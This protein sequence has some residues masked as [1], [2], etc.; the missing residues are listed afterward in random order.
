NQGAPINTPGWEAQ[1]AICADGR[2]LYFVSNRAGGFGGNDLWKSEL[3]EDG[4]WQDPVNLGPQINTSFSE[5]SP[6]IHADN[7]TLYFASSGWTGL[8]GQDT[9]MSPQDSLV[10]WER[11]RNL[12][13]PINNHSD[14]NGLQVT[15]NVVQGF[16]SS[17]DSTGQFH[18]YAFGLP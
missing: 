8:C 13:R 14:Q 12:G 15:M 11:P 6:Y 4:V 10:Q 9:V 1:P 2:T 3:G 7:R 16:L 5:A 17:K 18:I